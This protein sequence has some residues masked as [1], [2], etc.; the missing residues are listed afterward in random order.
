MD[1]RAWW[2]S[3]GTSQMETDALILFS[4][5]TYALSL[6]QKFEE[7]FHKNGLVNCD[8]EKSV[9]K[10]LLFLQTEVILHKHYYV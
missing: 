6:F 1:S 10:Q 5:Q 7:N 8:S 4:L 2:K 3:Q 9:G